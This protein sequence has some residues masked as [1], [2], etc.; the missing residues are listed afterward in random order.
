MEETEKPESLPLVTRAFVADDE[1]LVVRGF[2]CATDWELEIGQN[3]HGIEVYRSEADLRAD[4]TCAGECGVV[5]VEVRII[6]TV[7]K[8]DLSDLKSPEI[9]KVDQSV[10]EEIDAE[11]GKNP[12][13]AEFLA[14]KSPWETEK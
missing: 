3:T 13:L 10:I 6:R 2:M 7:A 1:R 4:R 14:Q 9:I 8:G 12:E 11:P 5:E